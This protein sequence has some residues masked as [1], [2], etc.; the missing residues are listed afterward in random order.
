MQIKITIAAVFLC[1]GVNCAV[2]Q[3]LVDKF[4]D[5]IL[6]KVA[7][8]RTEAKNDIFLFL[9]KTNNYVNIAVP[10][11]MFAAGLMDGDQQT[12]RDAMYVASSSAVSFLLTNLIKVVVKRP[13]PFIRNVKVVPLY[14][15]GGYSFPSGHT[16]SSFTTATALSS[17]YPKWYVI[18]PSYLWA[19]SVSYSRIYLGVHHPSDVLTGAALGAGSAL[20]LKFIKKE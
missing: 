18:A 15:A 1:W 9:S 6:I 8:N 5:R 12:R 13:R 19:S 10:V 3:S 2:A 20:S 11:G 7:D 17:V 16:S 4:D 14:R